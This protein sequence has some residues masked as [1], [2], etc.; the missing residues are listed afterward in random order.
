M[1]DLPDRTVDSKIVT[2]ARKDQNRAR[3][4]LQKYRFA[5]FQNDIDCKN[6]QDLYHNKGKMVQF[7]GTSNLSHSVPPSHHTS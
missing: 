1:K 7:E 4:G 6:H 5:K 3:I 2:L